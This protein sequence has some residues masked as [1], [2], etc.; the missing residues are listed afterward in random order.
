MSAR[1]KEA[2]EARL[3]A[4]K[5]ADEAAGM[6]LNA[7]GQLSREIARYKSGVSIKRRHDKIHNAIILSPKYYKYVQ[8][9][10]RDM[11]IDLGR[12]NSIE[13]AESIINRMVEWCADHV[14]YSRS[15]EVRYIKFRTKLYWIASSI[16]LGFIIYGFIYL[17]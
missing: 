6:V 3:K 8:G 16:I 1:E 11:Y 9:E 7:A 17:G 13:A 10:E 2:K 15:D 4:T 5:I 12:I 14:A